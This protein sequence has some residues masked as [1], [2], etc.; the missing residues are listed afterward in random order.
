MMNKSAAGSAKLKTGT[1]LTLPWVPSVHVLRV[2]PGTAEGV[3]ASL[4]AQRI[5]KGFPNQFGLLEQPITAYSALRDIQV[6]DKWFIRSVSAQDIEAEDLKL[7]SDVVLGVLDSGIDIQHP[8]F[9]NDLWTDPDEQESYVTQVVDET[10]GI[11]SVNF[12]NDITDVEPPRRLHWLS[13]RG[14]S[15]VVLRSTNA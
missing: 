10:H 7:K 15:T 4:E 2:K 14:I 11:D 12:T 5:G 9:A 3:L 6:D 1:R 8:A 13:E